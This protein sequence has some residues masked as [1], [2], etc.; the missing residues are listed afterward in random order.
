MQS[1][2][3]RARRRLAGGR[4]LGCLWTVFALMLLPAIAT[5]ETVVIDGFDGATVPWPLTQA[6]IGA[7]TSE[8]VASVLGGTRET[9][10][11]DVALAETFDFIQLGVFASPGVFDYNSSVG[12]DGKVRLTYDGDG[13]LNE[14]LQMTPV[15]EVAVRQFDFASGLPLDVTVSLSDNLGQ[16]TLMQSVN[17]AVALP[18]QVLS[19]DFAPLAGSLDLS[20]ITEIVVDL[21][22]GTGGD[23]RIEEIRAVPEPAGLVFLLVGGLTIVRRSRG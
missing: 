23:F 19:F 17:A 7:G 20:Q 5:A 8:N 10:L 11:L 3:P 1:C 13:S 15:V 22:A 18:G 14:D 6:T 4:H 12:A 9:E 21:D 16:E 2:T